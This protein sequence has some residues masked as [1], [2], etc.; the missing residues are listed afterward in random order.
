MQLLETLVVH[1]PAILFSLASL[2]QAWRA[3]SK[4]DVLH[5]HVAAMDSGVRQDLDALQQGHAALAAAVR[6]A[7]STQAPTRAP[8]AGHTDG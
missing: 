2:V 4:V 1:L 8:R 5:E 3:G 7:A 6:Q